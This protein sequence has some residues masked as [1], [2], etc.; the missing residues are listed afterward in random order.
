MSTDHDE[1]PPNFDPSKSTVYMANLPYEMRSEDI[2]HKFEKY[3]RIVR[4]NLLKVKETR[5]SK[6]VAFVLFATPEDAKK[7]VECTNNTLVSGQVLK[8]SMA[9]DNGRRPPLMR[10][11]TKGVNEYPRHRYYSP[12]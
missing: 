12:Y 5:K 1:L 6:G 10:S 8:A 11:P 7:C 2:Q 3:G 4:V 9:K